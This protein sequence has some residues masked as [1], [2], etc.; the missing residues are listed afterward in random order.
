M[1]QRKF[2]WIAILHYVLA[3][4]CIC[5]YLLSELH[6]RVLLNPVGR[7][8][9][10]GIFCLSSYTAGIMLC[11]LPSINK[12]LV[13]K[14][15]FLVYFLCY[16]VLLFTFTLFDP[17]FG[18]R[19]HFLLFFADP[20]MQSN[21]MEN[22]FNIIPFRTIAEYVSAASNG[23]MNFEIIATNLLGNFVALVPMALFLPLFF[24]CCRKCRYFLIATA[25]TAVVIEGLQL[26]LMAGACDIDDFILNTGGA[27]IAFLFLKIKTCQRVLRKMLPI[28]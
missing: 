24:R 4:A 22:N 3:L 8:T 14:S 19:N 13:M 15:T 21:Y 12:T 11:K 10:M 16:L 17:M 26:L 7:L 25:F 28:E 23:R 2:L 1:R 27:Y 6:P 9:L 18:R 5:I 20:V